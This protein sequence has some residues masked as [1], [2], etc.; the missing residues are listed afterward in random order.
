MKA[1]KGAYTALITPMLA[2]GTIDWEGWR[3]LINFQ[4]DQGIDGLVPL[5]TTGE[6][7][8]LDEDE[9][10]RLIAILMEETRGRAPVIIGTG[11]NDTRHAVAYTRRA[12][13][14]GADAALV[15]TPYYNKPNDS[16]LI[17]HFRAVAAVGLPVIIYNI[18]SRTGRNIPTGLME[19][20]AE[21][22][23]IL[24]VKEAS[25]DINQMAEVIQ[26]IAIPRRGPGAGPFWVL[27]GDDGLCL[28]LMA[29][30]GDGLIS[31]ISNLLPGKVAALTRACAAGNFE[32]ARRIH[33]ELLPLVKAVFIETNPAPIKRAMSLAG[34]PGGPARLP[35]GPIS[36]ASEAALR[37]AMTGLGIKL[38]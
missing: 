3:R 4:I 35:L 14:A 34:L 5:G 27:S 21:I 23:G 22:P 36:P 18:A 8:T 13:E 1:F 7:P 6:N 28:P 19:Q 9:E 16:G 32:E 17:G 29:L 11:S 24:G 15:V 31:V 10:D 12:R 30:G 37:A 26:R 25:G 20:L 38:I 2:D 33:Y